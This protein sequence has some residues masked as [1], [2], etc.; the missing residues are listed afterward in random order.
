MRAEVAS[1]RVD[2]RPAVLVAPL[3][4]M[5]ESGM[6]VRSVLSYYKVAPDRLLV[7]H[8]DIDLGFGR[9]RLQNGGGN[10]GHN[11]LRSIERSLGTREYAR[12]KLGVGRPP[13]E[14]DPVDHVLSRFS[15]TEREEV[16]LQVADAADVIE[17]WVLDPVRAQ[18]AAAHRR[19]TE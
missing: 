17:S 9:L 1:I 7:V 3:T 19:P 8:D 11:G 10:G 15:R 5:N 4:Y 16:D 6:A 2:A 13:G 14:V 18:E 12:L